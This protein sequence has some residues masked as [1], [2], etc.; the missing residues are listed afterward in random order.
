MPLKRWLWR[1]ILPVDLASKGHDFLQKMVI[2]VFLALLGIFHGLDLFRQL[3]NFV[4]QLLDVVPYSS[5]PG[6]KE[7]VAA[8]AAP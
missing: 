6:S 1:Y 5:V 2:S 7:I 3:L 8:V 4:L